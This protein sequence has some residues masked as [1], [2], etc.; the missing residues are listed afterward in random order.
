MYGPYVSAASPQESISDSY[1]DGI[2]HM[3]LSG[4]IRNISSEIERPKTSP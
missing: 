2:F 3:G 4:G 1:P